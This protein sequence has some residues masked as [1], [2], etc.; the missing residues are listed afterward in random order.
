MTTEELHEAYKAA[1][2]ASRE[3]GDAYAEAK[4]ELEA[5]IAKERAAFRR[6]LESADARF[7]AYDALFA[8]RKAELGIP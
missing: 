5:A 1:S 3:A 2:E 8:A 6:W 4:S 7:A